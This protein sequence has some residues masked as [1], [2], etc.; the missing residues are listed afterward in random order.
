MSGLD[1]LS[2]RKNSAAYSPGYAPTDL[3][4]T[5]AAA[6]TSVRQNFTTDAEIRLIGDPLN[7]RNQLIK[8]RLG[9]G[10]EE[11]TG[12]DKKYPNPTPE[13][14]ARQLEESNAGIDDLI[15][16]GRKEQPGIWEGIET[17]AEIREKGKRVAQEA[18]LASEQVNLR[19][20]STA[21][22]L[23]G[24]ILGGVGGAMTD[25]LNIMTLPLGAGEMKIAGAGATAYARALA[26]TAT[27]EGAIQA[28]IQAASIPQVKRWQ[29]TLGH[30]YGMSEIA[31]DL[32][33]GFAGGAGVRL[34]AEGI[35]P[36]LRGLR[37]GADNVSSYVLDKVALSSRELPQTVKDGLQYMSRAAYVD[38]AAPVP[39]RSMEELKAHREA[40]Q[41][42]AD[43]INAYRRPAPEVPNVSKVVTPRGDM[44]LDTQ[45]RVIDAAD[46]IT[47][48]K[49]GF[50]MSLQPR[51]RSNRV[52]SDVR[53]NEIAARLD[54]A[55]LGDSRVSN[56]GAP[57]VG[58][59]MMV[60]SGNGRIMALRKA[61]EAHPDKA[62][63]Y[64]DFIESKGFK[65]KGMKH[66]VLVRQ[67]V[68]ELTPDQRRQFVVFS[69]ED[70]ADR[71]STTERAMADAR[72]FDR[73]TLEGYK[74]GDVANTANATFVRDFLDTAVAPSERNAFLTPGGK[75]S[76]DGMRRIRAALLAKAYDDAN[77]IQQLLEDADTNI[78]TIGQVLTDIAGEWA[79][80]R[81][82]VAEG[83]ITGHLDITRDLMDAIRTIMTA[84]DQNRPIGEFLNQKGLFAETDLTDE[85]QA[86]I[87]GMY[88]EKLTRPL[89]AEKVKD[90]LLFY[91]REARTMQ[92]GPNLLGEKQI[93]AIDILKAGLKKLHGKDMTAEMVFDQAS[94]QIS[95][96]R[97]AGLL[98]LARTTK[99]PTKGLTYLEALDELAKRPQTIDTID[100]KNPERV[101]MQ[102]G[103][104][105][106]LTRQ[107]AG[108]FGKDKIMELVLGP[109]GAGKSSIISST[110][111]SKL[112]AVEIDSDR[113]KN[114]LPEYDEGLGA[115]AV[116]EESK[117]ITEA[118]IG[119]A[120]SKG[121]N[122]VHPIIGAKPDRVLSIIEKMKR[123]GY[124]VNV[125]LVDI[126]ADVSLQR[127]IR[128]FGDP[129]DGRAIPPEYVMSIGDGPVKTFNTLKDNGAINAYTHFNNDVP[130]GQRPTIEQSNDPSYPPREAADG[131]GSGRGPELQRGSDQAPNEGN[132]NTLAAVE[133]DGYRLV[134]YREA[135]PPI[136]E[137]VTPDAQL[138]AARSSFDELVKTDPDTVI[139]LDD[140]STIRLADYAERIKADERVLEAI[141]TCRLQ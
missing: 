65:T 29:E 47:S 70:V 133:L 7:K 127:I 61:Y 36:A 92:P 138:Q 25:P 104:I 93:D 24:N 78:K 35:A 37:K 81:L 9:R 59:D 69:N 118:I 40:V 31:T 41:K 116:H 58:P 46:L 76:Q 121:W 106:K 28:A 44:E 54:P 42:T 33:F 52:S 101:K 117:Q 74:G 10:I 82:E 60:E 139:T 110:L 45:L 102:Q 132:G 140:G 126:P 123:N 21:S 84:R 22:R 107:P 137:T 63:A 73:R 8:E 94:P 75:V 3:G 112:K 90:F 68:S 98:E 14:R 99:H 96:L 129:D 19:N 97:E 13:G 16:R 88:N 130:L 5:T 111:K 124:T 77:L 134:E 87:R 4:D 15:I 66:P 86:I 30:K 38:E 23:T 20:P 120:I 91:V 34:F 71:L 103:I 27:K 141:T 6:F 109:P 26:L 135:P 2:T 1:L 56:T 85:T 17:T 51:D 48:D 100:M 32:G 50:D 79:Q 57:I 62:Q 49:D 119:L 11:L 122:I 136:P 89:G 115:N 131:A 67:R 105:K 80:M 39:V 12:T 95:A 18:M 113:V 125:R 83:L 64:R 55:Q 114:L 72:L 43:D 108:G 128:R 53:I